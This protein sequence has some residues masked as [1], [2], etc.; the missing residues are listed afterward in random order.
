MSS[1]SSIFVETR[2]MSRQLMVRCASPPQGSRRALSHQDSLNTQE[3]EGKVCVNGPA[4]LQSLR[5]ARVRHALTSICPCCR[6]GDGADA[7][8]CGRGHCAPSLLRARRARGAARPRRTEIHFRRA[9]S[10]RTW[11]HPDPD[12]PY[13]DLEPPLT[14]HVLDQE[15]RA[16][17]LG[18]AG[19][20][21]AR[22]P[23]RH[24]AARVRARRPA[25]GHGVQDQDHRH[26]EGPPQHALKSS[27][28]SAD[29]AEM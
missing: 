27:V 22:R 1:F 12:P 7:G 15:Q 20:R 5:D 24:A 13:R 21:S 16:R 11:S 2:R 10:I 3:S 18:A 6:R 17:D 29:A 9:V 8:G 4:L 23:D 26:F 25:A 19:A 28:A 14:E